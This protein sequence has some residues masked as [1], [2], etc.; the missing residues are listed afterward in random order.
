MPNSSRLPFLVAS[1]LLAGLLIGGCEQNEPPSSYVARVGSHYLQQ[2]DVA[3]MLQ[4]MG[5]VPDSTQARQQV[6]GQWVENTLLLQEAQRLNLAEDPAVKRRLEEQ[7]RNALVTALKNRIYDELDQAPSEQEVRTYFERHQEQLTL[8]EPYVR[9][10]HLTTQQADSARTAREQLLSA[11]AAG[12]DSVWAQLSRRYA[13]QP[14]RARRLAGRF[15]PESRLFSQLPYV[16]DEL[17]ALREG[18]VAPITQDGD[19]F[20]LLQLVQRVDTGATPELEW[21]E[22]EIRRR[23]RIRHRKQMYAREV[24]RLRNRAKADNLIETP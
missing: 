3:R 20:H 17:D 16:R 21:V 11:R 6:I 10:R 23:L 14:A 15:L 22:G 18:E 2:D 24:Q 12:A 13:D 19:R 1:A 8:R 7:R 5:P 4:G 9:V